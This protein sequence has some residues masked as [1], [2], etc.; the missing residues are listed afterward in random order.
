M[1]ERAWDLLDALFR[2]EWSRSFRAVVCAAVAF[3]FVALLHAGGALQSLEQTTLDVR[4]QYASQPAAVDSSVVLATIDD[5]SISFARSRM[6]V[7]W[8]WPREFYGTLVEY[9]REGGAR[10]VMFDVL[11]PEPDFPR[12]N[13]SAQ[14]SDERF[15]TA[16]TEAGN[17][18]LAAQLT[19]TDTTK[20][21]LDSVH[22]LQRGSRSDLRIPSYSGALAPIPSFQKGAAALG[23]TNVRADRDGVVRRLPLVYR[24]SDSLLIPNFGL[25]GIRGD[26]SGENASSLLSE[27]PLGPSGSFLLYWY[28]PG[29]VN[30][31]FKDQYISIK[32]LIVSAAQ[33]QLGQ[34]PDVPPS[35]FKDKTVIVGATAAGLY[36][37]HSTPVGVKGT[38]HGGGGD[39]PGMEIFATFLSNVYQRHYLQDFTGIWVYF[40]VLLLAAVGAGLVVAWSGRIGGGFAAM[41]GITALY[42]GAAVGAFYYLLWW[43]PVVAPLLGLLSGFSVTSAVSYAVEGRKRRELR[44]L[45]QR[46]VSP[47]VVDEVVEN[48]EAMELGGKDLEGTVFFSDIKGFTS[49]SEQ[50]DPPEVVQELNEYLGIATD[51]VLDHR[52]MVDKFIGDAIMAVF[53][54]PVQ[55]QDHAEQACLAAVEMDRML[56]E[57]YGETENTERP[58]FRSRIGIHTGRIVVGNI[59]TERR[60]EYTAIGDAVNVA[61]RLEPANKQYGTSVLISESTYE[62]AKDAIEVRELDLLRVTGKDAPI[63]IYEV[64]APAGELTE[65]E[66]HLRDTFKEGLE[67]YRAQLWVQARKAFAE[68]LRARPDDGPSNLYQ[69]RVEERAGESLPASWKGV[70]EMDVGK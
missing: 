40:L 53:G 67:A 9:F 42:L 37:L 38:S 25:A 56:K 4:F 47:Q 27:L 14:Q 31:V 34:D 43:L 28:G 29:G 63:R 22:V 11:F 35:R 26:S 23:G 10:A 13:V 16:M 52:A 49:I 55:Y 58:P 8:P 24:L 50:M 36:D 32:S 19:P 12:A 7:G 1:L 21:P 30:G 70:H 2:D 15:A 3:G 69:K 62:L 54:A 66:E 64:L 33:L 20:N 46:Y 48:P 59:G 44:G 57:Y 65:Q 5:A 45:F 61:A 18:A 39:Y 41:L 51:I 68:I 60:V 6:K 17:V